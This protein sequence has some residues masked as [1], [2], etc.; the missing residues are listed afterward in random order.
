MSE[1]SKHWSMTQPHKP[2]TGTHLGYASKG[3]KT[4]LHSVNCQ[5]NTSSCIEYHIP[6]NYEVLFT[7]LRLQFPKCLNRESVLHISV[8]Y[9][10]T[11]ESMCACRCVQV[12]V[13]VCVCVCLCV[14]VYV[15]T[16]VKASSCCVMMP[17][18]SQLNCFMR[19]TI[20]KE[21]LWSDD[22]VRRKKG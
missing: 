9:Q 3:K 8:N 18:L 4:Y 19:A 12:C 13:C 22:T 1:Y 21:T 15:H 7:K 20:P 16:P 17:I 2:N 11:T 5:L 10:V 14:C 6:L